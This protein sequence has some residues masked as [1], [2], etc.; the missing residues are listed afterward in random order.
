MSSS[1]FASRK[2]CSEA[3][4]K[5]I[6]L[7]PSLLLIVTI[8]ALFVHGPI[9]QPLEYHNFADQRVIGG[10][11]RGADVWSNLGFALV[12]IWGFIRLYP[13]RHQPQLKAGWPGYALFLLGLIGTAA[14]SAYYHLAPDN[15]SL[16]WDRLPIALLCAGLL[17]AVHGETHRARDGW[18]TTVTLAAIAIASIAWWYF[19]GMFGRDDL[20]PY[21]LLQALPLVMIPLWQK[22][23][24]APAADQKAFLLAVGCYL[25][26]KAAELGDRVLF[27]SLH[28]ISGHTLKHLFATLAAAVI[29]WRLTQRGRRG[30]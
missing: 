20:R 16:I 10:V 21:V 24:R 28:A 26:A 19:T 15:F 18:K 30:E 11:L 9:S 23:Y 25:L 29:V 14:G 13:Q 6:F 5:W 7:A 2:L 4:T 8:I 3:P 27:D 12:G 17:A 22:A 1:L